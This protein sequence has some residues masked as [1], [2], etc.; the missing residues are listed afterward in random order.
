MNK[1]SSLSVLSLDP[2][3]VWLVGEARSLGL[4]VGVVELSFGKRCEALSG[5][6]KRIDENKISEVNVK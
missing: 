3:T 1:K 4:D 2:F 6:L 5:K